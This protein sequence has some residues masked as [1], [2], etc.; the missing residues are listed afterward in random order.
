VVWFDDWMHVMNTGVLAAAVVLLTLP[1]SAGFVAVAE[2]SLA[3]GAT[4]AIGWEI[5]EYFAFI[6]GGTEKEFAYEDTLGD[7]GLG[8]LGALTAA[9]L[10][11]RFS[12][13]G[14]VTALPVVADDGQR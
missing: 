3:F 6:S 12:R 10:L 4:A 13:S 7:L 8:V 9:V 2:R 1:R 5:A 14:T 11:Y